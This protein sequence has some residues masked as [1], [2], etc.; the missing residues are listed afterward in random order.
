MKNLLV[1]IEEENDNF[2]KKFNSFN[3]KQKN[4]KN[5]NI[6][7]VKK[8]FNLLFTYIIKVIFL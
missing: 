4:K 3:P 8:F 2:Y 6:T 7:V 5:G 1:F